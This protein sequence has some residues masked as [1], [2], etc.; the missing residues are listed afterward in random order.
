MIDHENRQHSRIELIKKVWTS[1]FHHNAAIAIWK[2]PQSN[3]IHFLADFSEKLDQ[4]RLNLHESLPGFAISP[5]LNSDGKRTL[6]LKPDLYIRIDKKI[7]IIEDNTPEG[8]L[9]TTTQVDH[10]TPLPPP[11]YSKKDKNSK[12]AKNLGE[13][14]EKSRFIQMIK[15][16]IE[17]IS[18]GHFDKVVLA[19]SLTEPLPKDFNLINLFDHLLKT[20]PHSFVSLISTPDHGTWMGSSPE[21]LVKTDANHHFHTHSLAATQPFI[22]DKT[23]SEVSWNQKEIEEQ[24][25]VSRFIIQQ[26]KTLRMREFIEKGPMT[27]KAGSLLHLKTRYDVDMKAIK[28]PT[29]ATEMLQLLHPTAAVCG[30]PKAS[31]MQFIQENE[32][33]H[34]ELYSGYLGPVNMQEETHL[35]VNLRCMQIQIDKLILYAGCGITHHSDPEKEWLETSLKCNNLQEVLNA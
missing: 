12:H 32:P 23:L 34:R 14:K 21:V 31:A 17:Q 19:R 1:C 27:V 6:F 29:F 33:L 13:P 8:L 7:K 26:F 9:P 25:M 3:T 2:I 20:R 5:F 30:L 28:R 15:Q 24:A 16:A 22:S 35:Y 4:S 18:S 11:Y 10:I